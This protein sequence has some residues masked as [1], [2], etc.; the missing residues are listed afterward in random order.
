ML[1]AIVSLLA[2]MLPLFNRAKPQPNSSVAIDGVTFPM[3][4]SQV[5]ERLGEAKRER[6]EGSLEILE[7]PLKTD[8]QYVTTCGFSGDR[9]V[10]VRG[11]KLSFEKNFLSSKSSRNEIEKVLGQPIATETQREAGEDPYTTLFFDVPVGF[12]ELSVIFQGNKVLGF[13]AK[14]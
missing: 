11:K 5:L 7:F 1:V 14:L 4:R 3:S 9:L 13:Q 8:V 12:S 2:V 6:K 10:S